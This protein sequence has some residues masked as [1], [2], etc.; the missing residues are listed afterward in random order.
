MDVAACC[1]YVLGT[2]PDDISAR[3]WVALHNIG[4]YDLIIVADPSR[5]V[6]LSFINVIFSLGGKAHVLSLLFGSI[7][8]ESNEIIRDD[9][10]NL[11]SVFRFLARSTDQAVWRSREGWSPRSISSALHVVRFFRQ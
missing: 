5:L 11:S 4:H 3:S 8:V 9:S 2:R 6:K 7:Y 1:R 10:A